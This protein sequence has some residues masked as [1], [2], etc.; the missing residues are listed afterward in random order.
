MPRLRCNATTRRPGGRLTPGTCDAEP[1]HS[2]HSPLWRSGVRPQKIEEKMIVASASHSQ[3]RFCE[4]KGVRK[5]LAGESWSKEER[6]PTQWV[7]RRAF[8]LIPD[9]CSQRQWNR[10]SP[11]RPFNFI[12]LLFGFPYDL[13]IGPS[14]RE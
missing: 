6:R 2:S 4:E 12:R 9:C 14:K 13:L 7:T 8:P 10:H 5:G 11:V 3:V 1:A